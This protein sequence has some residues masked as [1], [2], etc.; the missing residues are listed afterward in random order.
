[1]AYLRDGI[2]DHGVPTSVHRC[3]SC[4]QEFTVTPRVLEGIRDQWN[5]CLSEDC[6]SYEPMRD[7]DLYMGLGMVGVD[8][9]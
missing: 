9:D 7:V 2:N 8:D 1:M 6:D 5:E 3:D 4:G